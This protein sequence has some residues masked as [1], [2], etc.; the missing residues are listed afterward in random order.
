MLT[1]SFSDQGSMDENGLLKIHGRTKEL[2]IVG[3]ENVHP[4]E[5]EE[6]LRTHPDIADASVNIFLNANFG[7]FSTQSMQIVGVPDPRRGEVICAWIK[8]AN[9]ESKLSQEELKQFCKD[10]VS[11]LCFFF[12]YYLKTL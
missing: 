11:S 12:S 1:S 4:L 6:L 5:V 2:I 7:N 10:N 8:L 9:P 3:G